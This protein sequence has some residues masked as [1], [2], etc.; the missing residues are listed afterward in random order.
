MIN[1]L[2]IDFSSF[3]E[4][5]PFKNAALEDTANSVAEA[6]VKNF[7]QKSGDLIKRIFS[8]IPKVF[9]KLGKLIKHNTIV[10]KARANAGVPK[11]LK[12]VPDD[13]LREIKR[14]RSEILTLKQNL[15]DS[16]DKRMQIAIK[17][18]EDLAAEMRSIANIVNVG[19]AASKEV[20]S[21]KFE[22]S[23]TKL[24][25][26]QTQFDELKGKNYSD[27][28]EKLEHAIGQMKS[29][30]ENDRLFALAVPVYKGVD[31][32]SKYVSI[33]TSNSEKHLA[34]AQSLANLIQRDTSISHAAANTV[35]KLGENK[36]EDQKNVFE[37]KAASTKDRATLAQSASTSASGVLDLCKLY[38]DSSKTMGQIA[39]EYAEATALV[40]KVYPLPEGGTNHEHNLGEGKKGSV[41]AKGLPGWFKFVGGCWHYYEEVLD[42]SGGKQTFEMEI[43]DEKDPDK[44]PKG[45]SEE[46]IKKIRE[47]KE[48][49]AKHHTAPV[50]DKNGAMISNSEDNIKYGKEKFIKNFKDDKD[51]VDDIPNTVFEAYNRGIITGFKK[52]GNEI[53]TVI[54]GNNKL[55][56]STGKYS[57]EEFLSKWKK[58]H[59]NEVQQDNEG[60]RISDEYNDTQYVHDEYKD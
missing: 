1:F 60:N 51:K 47:K 24:Q 53:D 31:N 10:T 32:T 6:K 22:V 58:A 2:G 28:K 45:L 44:P 52:H 4:Y 9:D 55:G 21:G 43:K 34:V 25:K 7:M 39:K 19:K 36:D 42:K 40:Y 8:Y 54:V 11:D 49:W 29:V 12:E 30:C 15:L 33:I 16:E 3:D 38:I 50:Q 46:T 13:K 37:R 23:K 14:L 56:I 18:S 35:G 5:N 41:S 57:I 26:L 20:I 27:I 48:A 59:T 17:L